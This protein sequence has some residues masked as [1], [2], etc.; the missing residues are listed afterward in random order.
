MSD[1]SDRQNPN[2]INIKGT[3]GKSYSQ[4]GNNGI[5]HMSGGVIKDHA[6]VIGNVE[7]QNNVKNIFQKPINI[8]IAITIAIVGVVGIIFAGEHSFV[9]KNIKING[10]IDAPTTFGN[11]SPIT[12]YEAG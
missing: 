10:D 8:A 12:I 4:T 5:G 2:D 6:T 11:N 7:T 1:D 3:T 9:S